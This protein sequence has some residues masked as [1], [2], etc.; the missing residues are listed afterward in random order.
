MPHRRNIPPRGSSE[1]SRRSASS[2]SYSNYARDFRE[3][4]Y[5]IGATLSGKDLDFR[6]AH[7]TLGYFDEPL[8]GR[9]GERNQSN[10]LRIINILPEVH[11][12]LINS[13]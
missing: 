7:K 11:E 13:K 3:F 10:Q 9:L 5:G 8:W 6:G 1:R 2:S 12:C 4:N